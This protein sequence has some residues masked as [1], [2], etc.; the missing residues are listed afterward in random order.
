MSETILDHPDLLQGLDDNKR[1][2]FSSEFEKRK[3]TL[4][5]AVLFLLFLGGAG[6]HHFY[7]ENDRRGI[8]FLIFFWSFIPACIAIIELFF[9]SN[10]VKKFNRKTAGEIATR[11]KSLG[12]SNLSIPKEEERHLIAKIMLGV[13]VSILVGFFIAG[14]IRAFL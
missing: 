10:M 2:L 12:D 9:I 14:F 11:I 1:L 5:K 6:G 13:V 4:G 3:K 7:L 8:I